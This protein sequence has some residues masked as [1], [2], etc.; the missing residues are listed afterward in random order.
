[1]II[2]NEALVINYLQGCHLIKSCILSLDCI[3]SLIIICMHIRTCN[4]KF[5]TTQGY[6]A[7]ATTTS[8]QISR[9]KLQP[10]SHASSLSSPKP[11]LFY[12]PMRR[13]PNMVVTCKPK[14]SM[15]PKN[16]ILCIDLESNMKLRK[17]KSLVIKEIQKG[18]SL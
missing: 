18:W 14:F 4:T 10:I 5:H 6:Q 15:T 2:C 12:Y 16:M 9:G 13:H 11:P 7:L 8:M 17:T 3:F 1:M